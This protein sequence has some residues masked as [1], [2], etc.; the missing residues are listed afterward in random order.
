MS[1]TSMATPLVA[2]CAGV[3][4]QSLNA[5]GVLN[6]SAA[7]I[8]ALLINGADELPGQ[9]NPSEAGPS[10]NYN[11]GF[12]RVNLANSVAVPGQAWSS[13][14]AESGGLASE[15]YQHVRTLQVPD[16]PEG[17]TSGFTLKVTLVWTDPPGRFLQNDLDLIVM[18]SNRD[19]R[20]G[21]MG[22]SAEFDRVN[23][24]EQVTWRGIP[25][26]PTKVTILANTIQEGIGQPFAYAWRI[27]NST[28]E[29]DF[30]CEKSESL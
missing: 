21:N 9:Y 1:G 29:A 10:P 23:N 12:G 20:H 4:R 26:G 6:P 25:S 15:G 28:E 8:K 7:R 16:D 22:G 5:T 3:V 11:S 18:S 24:V 27:Y 19:E 17:T 14:S 30:V 2:G 13:G